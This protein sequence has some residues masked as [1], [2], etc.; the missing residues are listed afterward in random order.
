MKRSLRS[1]LLGIFLLIS[2]VPLAVALGLSWWQAR[3]VLD[4]DLSQG[5]RAIATRQAAQVNDTV[6]G[7][8]TQ[9]ERLAGSR[10]VIQALE[11]FS[12]TP[13]DPTARSAAESRVRDLIG[14]MMGT[15]SFANF[16]LLDR[17]GELLFSASTEGGADTGSSPNSELTR[18]VDRARTILETELS[19]M[20]LDPST[21]RAIAYSATPVF[22]GDRL[23][24]VL[25]LRI[26]ADR[27]LR[28]VD[29]Y[30][31]L[32][33][34]GET[35]VAMQLGNEAVVVAPLRRQPD[36]AFQTRIP[37]RAQDTQ[38][39]LEAVR[40]RRGAGLAKDH[41]GTDVYA[42]WRYIPSV[43]WGIVVKIDRSEAFA[44][45]D[46]L[47]FA[48][49][50]LLLA[51]ALVV[52]LIAYRE[53]RRL[54]KPLLALR[55]LT[56]QMAQGRFDLEIR[57]DSRN[58]IG[59]LADSFG[60]M[61]RRLRGSFDDLHRINSARERAAAEA[62]EAK[63]EVE[64]VN[65]NLEGMV[66]QRTAELTQRN[67]EIQR[68]LDDLKRTQQQLVAREKMASLGELTAG[69]AHEISNP[70]NF[71]NNFADL[72]VEGLSD[73]R[74]SLEP[75][76]ER[77]SENARADLEDLLPMLNDN[78]RRIHEHGRRAQ[79]IVQGMLELSRG[80]GGERV[81]EN[82][83]VFVRQLCR[84]T[85]Q[86]LRTRET[87][88]DVSIEFHLAEGLP[89]VPIY[90][91]ELS[92]AVHSILANAVWATH[93][94]SKAKIDGFVPH[95]VVTTTRAEGEVAITIRD[96]GPGIPAANL[97]RIFQP[98]FTTRPTGMGSTGLGLSMA[99]EIVVTQ[100]GGRLE[101]ESVEGEFAEF[102]VTLPA[103][104]R[105]AR[106]LD[107]AGDGE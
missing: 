34:S 36:A 65:A 92:R 75:E 6:A 37:I 93:E 69:V 99:W 8:E 95:I 13:A 38:P 35:V 30:V 32:G 91:A 87:G 15:E 73:L 9:T 58:E 26:D 84:A 46:R 89:S 106:V 104:A 28:G 101:V 80:G 96:N 72:S 53:A 62:I 59:E 78:L 17:K 24:G 52:P 86:G 23:L 68:T 42:V 48:I 100:H 88:N 43:R 97:A 82:I 19:D 5:L 31:G 3:R 25:A 44:S 21:G 18:V 51:T 61:A 29:N 22:N 40:G 7:V 50:G 76:A 103:A 71:V 57:I 79:R 63:N 81:P 33:E 20:Q 54:T 77:L 47:G 41:R 83:N 10:I 16:L 14:T 74:G 94:K 55:D 107:T 64:R 4:H 2:L 1:E 27:L 60:G 90:G 39:L 98:F 70:L 56:G 67:R 85:L 12:A 105:E 49:A 11:A 102:R 45:V 66:A